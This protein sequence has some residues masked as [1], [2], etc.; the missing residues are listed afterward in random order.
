[1]MNTESAV[2]TVDV[3]AAAASQ[4]LSETDPP[5]WIDEGD[6]VALV[7]LPEVIAAVRDAYL[8]AAA[9]E[10]VAM[11]KT[12]ASWAGG[13]MH[14]IGA[15]AVASGIAVSKTWAHTSGG[16][17]PLLAAWDAD[18]GRLLAVIQ[19]FAL[20]QL[21]TSAITGTATALLAADGAQRLAVIGSGK[22][23][24]G[25][26]AAVAAVR[27]IQDIAVY[28][29]TAEHRESFAARISERSGVS[30]RAATSVADALDQADVV[31]T[32]T[33]ATEPFVSAPMLA[34]RVHINAVGAITPERAELEPAVVARARRVVA[35][36]VAAARQLSPRELSATNAAHVLSLGSAL[37]ANERLDGEGV[38]IFK[39]LGTGISDLAVAE[40]VLERA[41]AADVG[42]PLIVSSRTQPKLWSI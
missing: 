37:A 11:P 6:V 15:T 17:T 20:G 29:P 3:R 12:F 22:Q 38:T 31:V 32:V 21:R 30:A 42:R 19:A 2:R 5:R 9:G 35:D 40:M 1:M 28:S 25:Q 18:T 8:R 23:A 26:A 16:A 4:A 39:A 36:D 13:T 34:E 7:S 10:I 41:H 33:R 14:A 24:E 27:D